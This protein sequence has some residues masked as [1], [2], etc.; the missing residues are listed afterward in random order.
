[1]FTCLDVATKVTLWASTNNLERRVSEHD[2]GVYPNAY[3][4]PKKPFTLV[5]AEAFREV[6]DAIVFEKQ[7]K[8]WSRKKKETLIERSFDKLEE[9]ARRRTSF[10]R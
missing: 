2:E 10:R 8:G 3:S 4:L 5:F 6:R 7:V 9:L 1:M